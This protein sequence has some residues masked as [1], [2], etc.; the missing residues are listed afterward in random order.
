MTSTKIKV[1]KFIQ[2]ISG[3]RDMLYALDTDGNVWI[4]WVNLGWSKIDM[5]RE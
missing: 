2:I 1:A 5:S 4:H 3:P